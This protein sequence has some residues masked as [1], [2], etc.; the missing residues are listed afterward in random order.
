MNFSIYSLLLLVVSGCL[1]SAEANRKKSYG[2][3]CE[4]GWD[5]VC[6][7]FM[8]GFGPYKIIADCVEDVMTR[9]EVTGKYY[10]SRAANICV[11]L[12]DDT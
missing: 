7:E 10:E 3:P 11:R 5:R 8:K 12:I 2:L 1:L 9:W 6:A 4:Y